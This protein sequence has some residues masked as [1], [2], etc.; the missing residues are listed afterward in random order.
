MG[1]RMKA[2]VWRASWSCG[3][4]HSSVSFRG[5]TAAARCAAGMRV[6]LAGKSAA[7]RVT[8]LTADG[9][10]WSHEASGAVV[11]LERI[12]VERG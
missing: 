11:R 10:E 8:E 2:R 1:A 6:N 12:E 9:G 4:A 3:D 5:F 7:W